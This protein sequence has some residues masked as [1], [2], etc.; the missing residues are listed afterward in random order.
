VT[1]WLAASPQPSWQVAPERQVREQ[2]P[3]H[4]NRQLEPV[5]QV[6][7]PPAPRLRVQ[8]APDSHSMWAASPAASEQLL[9]PWHSA[10]HPVPQVRS[11]HAVPDGQLSSQLPLVG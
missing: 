6:A 5:L 9:F 3:R 8:L 2:L 11:V 7:F 1:I 4:C 10:T